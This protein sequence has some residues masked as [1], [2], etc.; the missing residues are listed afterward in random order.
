[1]AFHGLTNRDADELMKQ[2]P[3]IIEQQ[4]ID[5]I[6]SQEGVSRATKSLKEVR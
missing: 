6:I 4:I 1:M 5:Y 2:D 3:K